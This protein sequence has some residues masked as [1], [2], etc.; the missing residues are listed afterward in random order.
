MVKLEDYL[1]KTNAQ[2]L[3]EFKWGT[4]GQSEFNKFMNLVRKESDQKEHR[5]EINCSYKDQ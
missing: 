2:L 1:L 3:N 4:Q 5:G